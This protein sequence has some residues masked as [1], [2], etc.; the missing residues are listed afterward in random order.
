MFWNC[1]RVSKQPGA[2]RTPKLSVCPNMYICFGGGLDGIFIFGP[3][4]VSKDHKIGRRSVNLG[5]PSQRLTQEYKMT[6]KT[7]IITV[8]KSYPTLTGTSQSLSTATQP[9]EKRFEL[10]EKC[11]PSFNMFRMYHFNHFISFTFAPVI[12]LCAFRWGIGQCADLIRGEDVSIYVSDVYSIATESDAMQLFNAV[13]IPTWICIFMVQL[14]SCILL[15]AKIMAIALLTYTS[16]FSGFW[17]PVS[18]KA[19]K[20]TQWIQVPGM[21]IGQPELCAFKLVGWLGWSN[22]SRGLCALPGWCLSCGFSSVE[23][24]E[25]WQRP[26]NSRLLWIA[27]WQK[28]NWQGL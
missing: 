12:W 8:T 25:G 28:E 23:C 3:F 22:K 27:P 4:E 10:P 21:G 17:T 20:Q 9:Y 15:M 18:R 24:Q 6:F 11:S 7:P 19:D 5:L 1:G 16:F 14:M 26:R 13:M 2:R